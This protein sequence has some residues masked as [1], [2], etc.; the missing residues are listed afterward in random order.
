MCPPRCF[1]P[2]ADGQKIWGISC[3][4][5]TLRSERNFG[6]GDFG[7]LRELVQQAAAVKADFIGLNPL[8]APCE[9]SP[10][11]ASPYSPS[12][13]RFINALYIQIDAVADYNAPSVQAWLE[14]PTQKK[15]LQR[16]R[17]LAHIDYDAVNHFKYHC[18]EL[19]YDHFCEQD[20]AAD[21]LRAQQFQ[22]FVDDK[23][24]ALQE[25]AA[26]E[27]HH[28]RYPS[29]FGKDTRF[30]CYLQWLAFGQLDTCQ[31]LAAD[32]GMRSGLLGDLA[33][34]SVSGGC[35]VQTN[36]HL[37]LTG[38]T[39]GAPP[40]PIALSGQDWGLPVL[41]PLAMRKSNYRH[42]IGL[43]QANMKSY[44]A[45]RID[46]AMALMRLWWCLPAEHDSERSGVYVYYP[47]DDL[48]ALLR[49][50]SVRN[51]CMVI[52][53]DLGV[54][55]AEF[56]QK[57][58][59]SGAYSNNLLYFEQHHD[60]Y[61]KPPHE[62]QV[63]ALLMV[64]NHDVSTLCDWWDCSDLQRRFDLGLMAGKD[65]LEA[66]IQ[67]RRHEKHKLLNWLADSGLLPGNRSL[68]EIDTAFDHPLCAAIHQASSR[69]ASKLLL[70]QLEDLQLMQE[71]VNIPGTYRQ[72]PNWRRKQRLN[73]SDIFASSEAKL[74]FQLVSEERTRDSR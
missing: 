21:S 47:I 2:L 49:L 19:M 50:E 38:A 61:F 46:H 23:R 10:D 14:N 43:L 31:R 33:V 52:G 41:N 40:D 12:D 67:Q 4:L 8:H 20:L 34:G 45:L 54:V 58:A 74:V 16:L 6:V 56:R 68:H 71:P 70:L 48:M 57:M 39:I 30:Y 24:A 7:D 73:T 35:E 42:F 59:A 27:C 55:P 9:D 62:H 15:E 36:Q 25:F 17:Q 64:T 3:Q 51:Q 53:E 18:L 5:Y 60:Q 28:N 66:Q 11:A 63:D 65:D 32:N 29:R 44:G 69:T 72:Y 22:N 37:Y 26:Y 13:R 1:D